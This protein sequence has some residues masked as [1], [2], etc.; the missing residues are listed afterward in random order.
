[1]LSQYGFALFILLPALF[2]LRR[3]AA[4]VVRLRAT[5]EAE[6]LLIV[7]LAVSLAVSALTLGEPRYRIP[8]D[9]FLMILAARE[10][11]RVVGLGD[12]KSDKKSVDVGG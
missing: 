1:M 10:L 4:D 7:P 5:A 3:R 12:E 9:G 8:C 2:A 6:I 11:A